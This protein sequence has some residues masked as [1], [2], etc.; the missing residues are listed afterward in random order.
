MILVFDIRADSK[1]NVTEYYAGFINT[2]WAFMKKFNIVCMT[3]YQEDH[4][5]EMH[6]MLCYDSSP[7]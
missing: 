4:Y 5:V 7:G 6:V 1:V 2:L 3:I